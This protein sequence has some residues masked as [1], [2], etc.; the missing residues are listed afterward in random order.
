VNFSFVIRKDNSENLAKNAQFSE[1]A[2][3][4]LFIPCDLAAL[5]LCVGFFLSAK[6]NQG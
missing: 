4:S 5:R 6:P 1:M 2:L 3:Q